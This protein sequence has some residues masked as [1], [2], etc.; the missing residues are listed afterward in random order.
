VTEEP[1][2]PNCEFGGV[3]IEAGTDTNQNGVLDPDEVEETFYVCNG[4]P[5]EKGQRGSNGCAVTGSGGGKDSFSGLLVLALI[6]LAVFFRRGMRG[7][8][9]EKRERRAH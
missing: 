4:E 7:N 1:P 5:G 3:K 6:P 9:A 8:D 2:G